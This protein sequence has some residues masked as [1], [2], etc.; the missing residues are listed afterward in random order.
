[1]L[2]VSVHNGIHWLLCQVKEEEKN[3]CKPFCVSLSL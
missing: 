1:M 3:E 2:Q